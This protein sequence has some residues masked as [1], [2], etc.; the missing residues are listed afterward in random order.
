[1]YKKYNRILITDSG[2]T[3]IELMVSI[4]LTMFILSGITEIYLIT[5]RHMEY[6][7]SLQRIQENAQV[8]ISLLSAQIR[9][10]GFVGCPKFTRRLPFRNH[11]SLDVTNENKLTLYNGTGGFIVWH[12][13]K[14]GALL[15]STMRNH[16]EIDIQSK[17]SF[18]SGDIV[19][20]SDCQKVEIVQID[21]V[22]HLSEGKEKIITKTP[23]DKLYGKN[24]ELIKLK[25]LAFFVDKTERQSSAHVPRYALFMQDERGRKNELVE[26]VDQMKVQ[27]DLDAADNQIQGVS[28]EIILSTEQVKLRKKWYDYVALREI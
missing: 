4:V 25:R 23:L 26:G 27:F 22:V 6:R 21:K 2:F 17:L 3:L 18:S 9:M 19:I 11:T 8:V 28:L 5:Q 12:A 10:A 20:L 7:S 14:L 24:S 1:M 15:Y 16:S 13:D